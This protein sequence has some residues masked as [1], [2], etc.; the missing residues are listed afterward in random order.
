MRIAMLALDRLAHA[1]AR[2]W[3]VG[4]GHQPAD[5]GA[6]RA[7]GRRHAVRHARF[8]ITAGKLAGVAPHGYSEDPAIDAKVWE[9]LHIAHAVRARGRVRPDPQPGRFPAARPSRGWSTRRWSPRSTASRS[10]RILPVYEHYDDRVALCRDQ[11]CRPRTLAALCRD[12]PPRHPAR[13]F[14]VRSDRQR[15]SA[16]LRPHPPR[17]GRGRS[18]PRRRAPPA[19][20]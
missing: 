3:P 5:R 17:Q 4:A 9:T 10:D 14:P 13:R 16:V 11:R 1:A 15:R 7:R 2:L 19:A 18:D 6:G 20:A 8:S 12:D